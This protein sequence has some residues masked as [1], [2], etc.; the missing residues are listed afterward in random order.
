MNSKFL[1]DHY[2]LVG[3]FFVVKLISYKII[4]DFVVQLVSMSEIIMFNIAL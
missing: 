1:K 4:R 2:M 3:G